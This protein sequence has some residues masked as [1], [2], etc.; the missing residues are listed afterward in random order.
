MRPL[1]K[2]YSITSKGCETMSDIKTPTEDDIKVWIKQLALMRHQIDAYTEYEYWLETN[3][4]T[5]EEVDQYFADEEI[6]KNYIYQ[7]I[8]ALKKVLGDHT[9]D[10]DTEKYIG[11]V[12]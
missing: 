1:I 6:Q 2:N 11:G 4:M 5:D 3:G 8:Q 7:A 9:E 12:K 10:G